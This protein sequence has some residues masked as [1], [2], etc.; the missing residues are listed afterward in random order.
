MFI[1]E[2]HPHIG[3]EVIPSDLDDQT[4]FEA[5]LEV[6][7]FMRDTVHSYYKNEL[8]LEYIDTDA[9]P[10]TPEEIEWRM[11]RLRVAK[12]NNIEYMVARHLSGPQ[13][14]DPQTAL[15]GLLVTQ[16]TPRHEAAARD[17]IEIVEWNV[18]PRERG[19]RLHRGLGSIMLAHKFESV[20]DDCGVLLDVA[21]TNIAAQGIYRHYG[22]V[23]H[24]APLW[25][26]VF[27]THHLPM[28]TD[29]ATLKRKL[30]I[31]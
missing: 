26:G 2:S 6:S 28:A 19:T 16:T 18:V 15:A 29:A 20:P 3:I 30:H 25:H 17:A 11:G 23:Q 13:A 10:G 4:L 31:Q 9:S 12:E 27:A 22:F 21:E 1:P 7:S 24:G 5:S 8:G 14:A